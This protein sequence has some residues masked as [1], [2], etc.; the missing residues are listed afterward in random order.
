[1]KHYPRPPRVAERQEGLKAMVVLERFFQV[2][3]VALLFLHVHKACTERH[4]L[5]LPLGKGDHSADITKGKGKPDQ[6]LFLVLKEE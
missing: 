3:D 1:M 2:V 6:Y 5:D 4:L